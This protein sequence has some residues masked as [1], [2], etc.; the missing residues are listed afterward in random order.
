MGYWIVVGE[1]HK[2][3]NC[4]FPG[5]RWDE[6]TGIEF[7]GRQEGLGSRTSGM[8]TGTKLSQRQAEDDYRD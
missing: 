7:Q 8:G 1:E 5:R 3:K 6:V 4:C 2:N